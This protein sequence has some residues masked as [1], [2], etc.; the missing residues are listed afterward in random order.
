MALMGTAALA[1]WWDMAPE[2]RAEFEDWHSHEHFR[3][4]L[5]IPGFR[6]ATRWASADG[7]EGVFQVYELEAYEVLSSPAYQ[8]RLNAPTPWSTRMMPHHRHMVRSQCRVLESAGSHTARHALTVRLSPA[9]GRD[10]ALRGALGALGAALADRPGCVGGH[11]LRHETPA[12]AQTTEQKIRGGD[13]TADWVFIATGYDLEALRALA[14]G[15]LSDAALQA[16]GAA[17]GAARGL[18]TLSYSA[19]PADV[20]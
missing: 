2:M 7:G 4:R 18:Y 11:L 5:G 19:T 16:Q 12:I 14:A 8:A 1:M 15:E 9:A 17:P 10:G 3:E 13:G 20:A 6:R